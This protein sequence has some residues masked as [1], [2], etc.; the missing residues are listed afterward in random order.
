M[1]T[2]VQFG[3]GNIGRGFL[4]QL[5]FESGFDTVFVDVSKPV[6]DDLNRRGGYTIHI[7]SESPWT[8]DVARVSAIDG[9]DIDAVATAVSGAVVASTAVGQAALPHIA[10]VV[11]R[12][13][14]QRLS[15]RNPV[16]LDIVVCENMIDAAKHLKAEVLKHVDPGL[17]GLVDSHIGFVDASI[18]RMVPATTEEQRADDPLCVYVEEYCELPVDAEAFRGPIPAIAHLLP[19]KDFAGYVARKLY[20]HNAAHAATAYLGWVRGHEFIW[21][22]IADPKVSHVVDLAMEESCEGLAR[23][24]RLDRAELRAHW[25]DLKFRFANKAL[26]DRIDR[27]ARDPER[28]LG[29]EDRLIGAALMCER[30]GIEPKGLAIAAAAAIRYDHPD[31]PSAQRIQELYRREGFDGVI[32]KVCGLDPGSAIARL[33]YDVL[34]ISHRIN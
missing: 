32:S 16:P 4:G 11:A 8:I 17:Y 25:D 34:D 27:V 28:K 21:E 12:G 6:I 33:I 14:V 7:A 2:A 20:V 18:G 1:S 31:D 23:A 19:K 15:K 29:K 22:A 13:V 30:Q 3:A 5:Y 26:G 24:Y 9:R 10:P